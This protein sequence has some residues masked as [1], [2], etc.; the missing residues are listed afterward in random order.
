MDALSISEDGSRSKFMTLSLSQNLRAEE[1]RLNVD[2]SDLF[3]HSSSANDL[4]AS[5]YGQ[6]KRTWVKFSTTDIEHSLHNGEVEG[7]NLDLSKFVR[8]RPHTI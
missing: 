2:L 8:Y 1:K 3:A 6:I 4:A 7:P 5:K